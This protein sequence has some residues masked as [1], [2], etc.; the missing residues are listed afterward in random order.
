MQSVIPTLPMFNNFAEI[1]TV[2]S[3][4]CFY[5]FYFPYQNI[6]LKIQTRT[7]GGVKLE[8]QTQLRCGKREYT[9]TG[10]SRKGHNFISN[11]EF[12]NSSIALQ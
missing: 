3:Y 6:Q 11:F 5:V 1:L 10:K 9:V 12:I 7:P 4:Q 8:P 2:E